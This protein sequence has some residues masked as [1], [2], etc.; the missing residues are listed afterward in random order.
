MVLISAGVFAAIAIVVSV[1][2]LV[3]RSGDDDSPAFDQRDADRIAADIASGDEQRTRAAIGV[4]EGQPFDAGAIE[5][6]AQLQL[7]M[8]ASTATTDV[9]GVTTATG[10]VTDGSGITTSAIFYLIQVNGEWVLVDVVPQ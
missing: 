4:P 10:T 5:Q 1:L 3:F 8:D 6:L 2:I 7:V 9:D